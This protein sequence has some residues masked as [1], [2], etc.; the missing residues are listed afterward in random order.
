MGAGSMDEKVYVC[1]CSMSVK[2]VCVRECT[3]SVS[4]S[5]ID[6]VS[7]SSAKTKSLCSQWE[8]P[9]VIWQCREFTQVFLQW[10]SPWTWAHLYAAPWNH[11]WAQHT[12][13]LLAAVLN[14]VSR[15]KLV[16]DTFSIHKTLCKRRL[17]FNNLDHRTKLDLDR[18]LEVVN[19]TK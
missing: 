1:V 8:R 6:S 15:P 9:A 16:L 3:Q 14:Y 13:F 19:H 7:L 17:C 10:R 5:E 2:C 18:G 4:N 11:C 12:G